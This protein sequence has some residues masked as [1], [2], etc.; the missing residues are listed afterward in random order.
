MDWDNYPKVKR[1]WKLRTFGTNVCPDQEH[2]AKLRVWMCLSYEEY[3]KQNK[4]LEPMMS[5]CRKLLFKHAKNKDKVIIRTQSFDMSWST[6]TTITKCMG[7]AV[8]HCIGKEAEYYSNS[9]KSKKGRMNRKNRNRNK[10]NDGDKIDVDED[11]VDSDSDGPSNDGDSAD[12]GEGE[13]SDA[14]ESQLEVEEAV[15]NPKKVCIASPIPN[16]VF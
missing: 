16:D 14:L 2:Y 6:D 4:V 10:S 15:G 11:G 5:A 3:S 8:K 7:I 1:A 12:D 13:S 9:R